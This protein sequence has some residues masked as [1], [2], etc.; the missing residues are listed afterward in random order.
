MRNKLIL[1]SLILSFF[2]VLSN[3]TFASDTSGTIDENFHYAWGE[4]VGFIDFANVTISDS[5]LSGSIYG[6]NIGWIDLST[7]TNTTGGILGGYAWG[8]NIGWMDFSKASIGTD[9]IFTGGAYGEN[10]GWITFGTT[11]NK[12]MTDWRPLN[13]RPATRTSSGSYVGFRNNYTV[14]ATISPSIK[15]TKILKM[16][17]VNTDVKYLQIFLNSH[18]FSVSKIG[19]GSLGNETNYFGLKTKQALIK[20]QKANKLK[21]DGIVGPITSGIINQLNNK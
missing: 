20:F 10:I 16:K 4:N 14:P 18:G 12:V 19:A 13:A 5:V 3:N 11:S 1:L 17:T 7:V 21:P 2:L 8:E 6:E 15:L 9:G